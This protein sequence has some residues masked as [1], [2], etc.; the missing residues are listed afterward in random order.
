METSTPI[1]LS[2]NA[3]YH[4]GETRESP[5]WCKPPG[6]DHLP[7]GLR[8][9]GGSFESC[10]TFKCDKVNGKNIPSLLTRKN[11]LLIYED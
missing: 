8:N 5:S 4:R 2:H 9:K 3:C 6:L 7:G 11:Y 10:L 1:K